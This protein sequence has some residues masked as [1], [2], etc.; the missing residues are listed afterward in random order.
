MELGSDLVCMRI[1]GLA[2]EGS[3]T[4]ISLLHLS[5]LFQP[6]AVILF[7]TFFE[8]LNLA[9]EAS[10]TEGP[11]VMERIWC[12]SLGPSLHVFFLILNLAPEVSYTEGPILMQHKS[13]KEDGFLP[14][15]THKIG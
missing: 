2:D 4:Q 12:S 5:F 3:T 11:I 8:S 14:L 1:F 13:W 10:S 7:F 9:L 6:D 15:A